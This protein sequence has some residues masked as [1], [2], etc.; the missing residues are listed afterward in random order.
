MKLMD[1]LMGKRVYTSVF[2]N[3]KLVWTGRPREKC[4]LK[5]M[6]NFSQSVCN[7]DEKGN[8]AYKLWM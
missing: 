1:K 8:H 7:F 2:D 3:N 4:V 5:V 6:K